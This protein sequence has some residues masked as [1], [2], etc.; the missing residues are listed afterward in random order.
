MIWHGGAE[1]A[2]VYV[3][4]GKIRDRILAHRDDSGIQRFASRDLFVTWAAVNSEDR[5]GVETY[6]ADKWRPKVG[7]QHPNAPKIEVNSPW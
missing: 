1:P 6:L 5:D 3:G 4:Q 2:V 7:E